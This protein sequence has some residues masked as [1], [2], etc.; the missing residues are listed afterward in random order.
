MSRN[1]SWISISK[2]SLSCGDLITKTSRLSYPYRLPP[3]FADHSGQHHLW[4]DLRVHPA[5]SRRPSGIAPNLIG[6]ALIV[7]QSSTTRPARLYS[8]T[9]TRIRRRHRRRQGQR[10]VRRWNSAYAPPR[11]RGLGRRR[12]RPRAPLL[13]PHPRVLWTASRL[14]R[15]SQ[16]HRPLRHRRR[17]QRLRPRRLRSRLRQ[18]TC[19]GS[20]T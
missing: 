1:S 6:L 9:P 18:S 3:G 10:A 12:H 13:T 16:N 20:T 7:P 15:P 17:L 19:A 5:G 11:E 8:R 14:I 4:A 2:A